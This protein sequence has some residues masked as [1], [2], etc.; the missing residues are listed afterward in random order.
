[1]S[2]RRIL[3]RWFWPFF[4]GS[5]FYV[6]SSFC[7]LFV[8]IK[9]CQC[10][11]RN[12]CHVFFT[13][14]RWLCPLDWRAVPLWDKFEWKCWFKKLWLYILIYS[15]VNHAVEHSR[16]TTKHTLDWQAGKQYWQKW[17][18]WI[19]LLC[20]ISPVYDALDGHSTKFVGKDVVFQSRVHDS[21]F[22]SYLTLA[23]MALGTNE[24]QNKIISHPWQMDA[25]IW[26]GRRPLLR[27]VDNQFENNRLEKKSI[28]FG[29]PFF[30]FL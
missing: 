15:N 13:L 23:L 6:V 21:Y 24:V 5:S 18:A 26:W 27:Q 7:S 2:V 9:I 17:R 22:Y 28:S 10:S 12:N 19:N 30:L 3:C 25:S 11:P 29:P 20:L 14:S 4:F 16:T 8:L 1:M